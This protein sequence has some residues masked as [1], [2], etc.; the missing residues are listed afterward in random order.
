LKAYLDTN[1]I[2]ALL[3]E[4]RLAERAS[5]FLSR[6][7]PILYISD[8]AAAEFSATLGRRVRM[9]DLTETAARAALSN[10]DRWRMDEAQNV[11]LALGD[12]LAAE[13]FLRRLDLT[14]LAPDAL[15]IAM[16]QRIGAT[17]A[18]F[19]EK[20]AASARMLGVDVAAA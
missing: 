18:T 17:L 13:G 11:A 12:V 3:I 9:R 14:L 8:F 16:C 2:V 1:V 6:H 10:F 19:D 15:H 7:K 5:G 20:M 4:D